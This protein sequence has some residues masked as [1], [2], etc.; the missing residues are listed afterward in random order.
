VTCPY[1]TIVDLPLLCQLWQELQLLIYDKG[2]Q[3][4]L[5]DYLGIN[6]FHGIMLIKTTFLT[7]GS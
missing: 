1:T 2:R 6:G 7:Y 5:K 4:H 3:R